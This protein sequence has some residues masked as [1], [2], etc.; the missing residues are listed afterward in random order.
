MLDASAEGNIKCKT[1]EE[2]YE[3]IDNMATND[4][5]M[6]SERGA[7]PQQ[8][9]VLQLQSHDALLAQNKIITQRLENL[10]KKLSQFPKELQNVSQV[11]Q[12]L[13][14]LC[15]GDHIKGQCAV[16]K[17]LIEEVNYMGNQNQFRPNNYN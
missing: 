7:P 12:K 14:E 13:C 16:P 15:G 1:P 8:K 5:E 11:Q 6:H 10:T 2:V 3:L 9:G 17:N 4:N